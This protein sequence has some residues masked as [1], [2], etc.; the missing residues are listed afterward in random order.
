MASSLMVMLTSFGVSAYL[1][2]RSGDSSMN[3]DSYLPT[4]VSYRGSS[5]NGYLSFFGDGHLSLPNI[6]KYVNVSDWLYGAS[7]PSASPAVE[8][9]SQYSTPYTPH[10]HHMLNAPTTNLEITPCSSSY[11][12]TRDNYAPSHTSKAS[13][14]SLTFDGI[15]RVQSVPSTTSKSTYDR[16]S[17]MLPPIGPPVRKRLLRTARPV[18]IG[19]SSVTAPTDTRS[20]RRTHTGRYRWLMTPHERS[21]R[22]RAESDYYAAVNEMRYNVVRT[23]LECAANPA[24]SRSIASV[25]YNRHIQPVRTFQ[26]R[27]RSAC[28]SSKWTDQ[29]AA[30]TRFD[31]QSVMDGSVL[32]H[33][34]LKRVPQSRIDSVARSIVYG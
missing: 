30:V 33:L 8:S 13:T 24:Q 5:P 34:G 15:L 17:Y 22:D 32:Q 18:S 1:W 29:H 11:Q 25:G 12:R 6:A 23:A 19:T 3:T 10:T 4:P 2:P 14:T 9:P 7:E 27:A 28:L 20:R 16:D 31:P 21:V 26:E